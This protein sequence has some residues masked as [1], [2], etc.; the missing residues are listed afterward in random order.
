M[1]TIQNITID[2][3]GKVRV[4]GSRAMAKSASTVSLPEYK[5]QMDAKRPCCNHPHPPVM[6][7]PQPKMATKK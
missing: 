5:A 7:C 3:Q 4:G 6:P 1:A 2:S